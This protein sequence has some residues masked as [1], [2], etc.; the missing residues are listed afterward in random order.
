MEEG[1]EVPS[2]TSE[3]L[4]TETVESTLTDNRES[5]DTVDTTQGFY[6]SNPAPGES[7]ADFEQRTMQYTQPV[8]IP[9]VKASSFKPPEDYVSPRVSTSFLDVLETQQ[10]TGTGT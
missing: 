9:K 3:I 4:P 5:V 6:A 2:L 10:G 8:D 1:G 7:S